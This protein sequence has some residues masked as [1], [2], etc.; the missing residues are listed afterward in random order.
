M[1]KKKRVGGKGRGRGVGIGEVMEYGYSGIEVLGEGEGVVGDV[2]V[3]DL[4][5]M[6]GWCRY[7]IGA[8]YSLGYM[9]V[10]GIKGYGSD[11]DWGEVRGMLGGVGMVIVEDIGLI[12]GVGKGTAYSMGRQVG[13]MKGMCMGMG[14]GLRVVRSRD[15]HGW[16]RDRYL[17]GNVELMGRYERERVLVGD[18]EKVVKTE[19]RVVGEYIMGLWGKDVGIE[20]VR[21]GGW[22]GVCD[23]VCMMDYVL[24]GKGLVVKG[25]DGVCDDRGYYGC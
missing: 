23:A 11:I 7:G 22:D 25:Y 16:V 12:Y 19:S 4:G 1:V 6:G 24:G 14:V 18:R 10:V 20:R 3:M 8:G 21:K 2:L 15:W 9:P 17:M 5:L 13:V